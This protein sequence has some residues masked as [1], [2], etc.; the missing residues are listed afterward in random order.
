MSIADAPWQLKWKRPRLLKI[1]DASTE[2]E[3]IPV[4]HAAAAILS[5]EL[6]G[7][8]STSDTSSSLVLTVTLM[9]SSSG[10]EGL[11]DVVVLELLELGSSGEIINEADWDEAEQKVPHNNRKCLQ[12]RVLRWPSTD[13]GTASSRDIELNNH[14]VHRPPSAAEMI[15]SPGASRFP[16][17]PLLALFNIGR[18]R[19]QLLEVVEESGDTVTLVSGAAR[20]KSRNQTLPPTSRTTTKKR[21]RK[22]SGLVAVTFVRLPTDEVPTTADAMDVLKFLSLG[23]EKEEPRSDLDTK[24]EDAIV[25]EPQRKTTIKTTDLLLACLTND[26]KVHFYSP[27]SLLKNVDRSSENDMEEGMASFLFGST[28]L[29]TVQDTILPLSQP[30]QTV[31]L[32]VPYLQRRNIHLYPKDNQDEHRD[33]DSTVVLPTDSST[34]V[35]HPFL[36]IFE[37]STWDPTL[38][39]ATLP[40]QTKDN[41]PTHCVAAFEYVCIAGRGR[42]RWKNGGQGTSTADPQPFKSSLQD[43]GGFVTFI[44]TRSFSE[45][46][47]LFLPFVPRHIS[48]FQWGGMAFLLVTGQ[49]HAVVIRTDASDVSSVPCGTAP[50]LR[51]DSATAQDAQEINIAKPDEKVAVK[52]FQIL[53]IDLPESGTPTHKIVGCDVLTSPPGIVILVQDTVSGIVFVVQRSMHAIDLVSKPGGES[54]FSNY[55]SSAPEGQMTVVT[56]IHDPGHAAPINLSCDGLQDVWCHLGQ[57]WCFVA[58][59]RSA[60]FLCLEGSNSERGSFVYQLTSNDN[61]DAHDLTSSNASSVLPVDPFTIPTPGMDR[62]DLGLLFAAPAEKL[63]STNRADQNSFPNEKS[64]DLDDIVV[65]AMESISR[66]TFRESLRYQS[67]NSPERNKSSFA[68]H[69]KSQRLLRHCSSWT[70]LEQSMQSRSRFARDAPAV[71]I[72]T[73]KGLFLL[74]LRKA[75][76][77]S[78]PATPFQQVLAWLSEQQDYFTAASLAL[79]LLRDPVSLRHLWIAYDK[80]DNEDERSKLE[81][82]LDGICPIYTDTDSKGESVLQ[83]T[84]TQ[85]ADMT[86]GCLTK[87]GY[88]MSSTLEQ[89][90]ARNL[91]YDPP[92]ASLML[93]ATAASAVS[94]DEELINSV[95][96]KDYFRGDSQSE[97]I[98]WPVRCLLKVGVARDYLMTVLLLLNT[99]IPDELRRR[100]RDGVAGTSVPSLDMCKSL[101]AL[102]VSACPDAAEILLNL[103][104]EKSR[105]RFWDSLEH[106]TRLELSI[107]A[108]SEKYPLL[109]DQEVRSWG[110]AEL[111]KCVKS[112]DSASSVIVSNAMPSLWLC[113]LV[114]SCLMNAGCN[115]DALMSPK[116]ELKEDSSDEYNL[117]QHRDEVQNT[118]S[119][120]M[121]APCSGGLDFGLLIPALLL[122]EHRNVL[123]NS[124]AETCTRLLLNAA[125]FVAGR[126]NLD[127]PMFAL[128]SIALM[129]Q[130]TLVG[131]VE[132]GAN[133]VGGKNG[134]VLECCHIL[135]QEKG[136]NMDEAEDF[137]LSDKDFVAVGEMNESKLFLIKPCHRHILWLL[138]DHVLNVRTYGEFAESRGKVDPVFAS[139]TCLR[140]WWA[141]TRQELPMATC[142]LM[143]W[144]RQRLS[145]TDNISSS[146]N[147]LVCA[148]LVR[149]LI[150]PERKEGTTETPIAN[151][152]QFNGIFLVQLSRGCCGLVEAL[153]DYITDSNLKVLHSGETPTAL[154]RFHFSETPIASS[155]DRNET[156]DESFV[157]A[158][159]SFR[160]LDTSFVDIDD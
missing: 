28:L 126:R 32:S 97:A 132:A 30:I 29:R 122:L 21:R 35:K 127:E 154:A 156:L 105:L 41:V 27:R 102:I 82:L 19:K 99:T 151:K 70:K 54:V 116:L 43:D 93:V 63:S 58:S 121:P 39:P 3:G 143:Q 76:V 68:L 100:D 86:V 103:V 124:S 137:L 104:D 48:P 33:V 112:E 110:L 147:R 4:G 114:I 65:K 59:P 115:L 17:N 120:L 160:D 25:K 61:D 49:S 155:R 62:D 153:P 52:R 38:D 60:H 42:Q 98:L 24:V 56:T 57:G 141:I 90:L 148:A 94:D 55:P 50:S 129:R 80:I 71:S 46:R 149:A 1:K 5:S 158:A 138:E 12:T 7:G 146:P 66:L 36:S 95:M 125:C 72:R 117:K 23:Q 142:W 73:A 64:E 109:R 22:L 67:A 45:K 91:K 74:S 9:Q 106:K 85:L 44:S 134:L 87:G 15:C 84:L 136:M 130:C 2:D 92:R 6:F 53:P 119:A 26:G 133:L 79:D 140:T 101:V 145:I 131:D 118:R 75:A 83:S 69:E 37:A 96:G 16:A 13:D 51:L 139:I 113:Q 34:S 47:T 8:E 159:S 11:A 78:G 152:L 77:E 81:S 123:W 111:Q 14:D 150:W 89:F 40:F 107:I 144:L 20:T 108:V 10:E 135:M 88:A 18:Q 31:S 128:N 157:S